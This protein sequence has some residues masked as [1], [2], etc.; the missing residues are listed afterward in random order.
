MLQYFGALL[1]C[2]ALGAAVLRRHLMVWK[3]FVP[4][5]VMVLLS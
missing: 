5:C 1:F 3:V 2:S 4:R